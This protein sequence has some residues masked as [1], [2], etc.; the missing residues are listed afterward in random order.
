MSARRDG[1]RIPE[2]L[3]LP[4]SPRETISVE[5]AARMLGCSRWIVRKLIEEGK[6]EA[7]RLRPHDPSSKYRV[8]Y[9]SV[10]AYLEQLH[11][12]SGLETRF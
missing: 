10:V 12:A 2:N 5:T 3:L 11:S 4:W 9:S 7:Y 8:H 1:F 6:V